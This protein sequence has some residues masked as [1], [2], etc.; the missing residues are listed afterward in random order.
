[1]T[2]DSL[3]EIAAEFM[4]AARRFVAV[5]DGVESGPTSA[6][7]MQVQASLVELYGLALRMPLPDP[8]TDTEVEHPAFPTGVSFEA[9]ATKLGTSDRYWEIFDPTT[10]DEPVAGSLADDI[11][12]V[13]KDMKEG[14]M[15]AE[16]G[17]AA[18]ESVFTWRLLFESHWGYHALDALRAI[19]WLSSRHGWE[20]SRP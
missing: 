5:V 1:M 14:L 16:Q 18:S 7:L 13:Y 2:D 9:V 11:T 17:G 4:K 3:E 6:F 8:E 15:I 20:N 12:D 10:Q 19:Y